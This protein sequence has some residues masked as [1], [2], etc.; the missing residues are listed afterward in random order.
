VQVPSLIDHSQIELLTRQ[1]RNHA[2]ISAGYD[3]CTLHMDIM[4]AALA[5]PPI[6]V[7]VLVLRHRHYKSTNY[8]GPRRFLIFLLC[9]HRLD[10]TEFKVV[11]SSEDQVELSFSSAYTPSS[12]TSV[13][14]HVDKRC[15]CIPSLLASISIDNAWIR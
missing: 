12:P 1:Q 13:H 9:I 3:L 5:P 6:H 10:S 4:H 15:A 7:L 8:R 2:C 14:L 11:V